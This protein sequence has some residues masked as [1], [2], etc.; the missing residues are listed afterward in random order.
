[1]SL[2]SNRRPDSD[3]HRQVG[4]GADWDAAAG[5]NHSPSFKLRELRRRRFDA[6]ARRD[7]LAELR[8]SGIEDDRE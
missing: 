2:K 4:R 1:M 5:R 3:R 6:R 8:Y 7:S